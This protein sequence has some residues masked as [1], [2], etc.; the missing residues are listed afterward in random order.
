MQSYDRCRI[1]TNLVKSDLL[2]PNS[3]GGSMRDIFYW[4]VMCLPI[5]FAILLA[6]V[7]MDLVV[8]FFRNLKVLEGVGDEKSTIFW[9]KLG[10]YALLGIPA[11]FFYTSSFWDNFVHTRFYPLE[12]DFGADFDGWTYFAPK[13]AAIFSV[14]HFPMH[15]DEGFS[16]EDLKD[17]W[18]VLANSFYCILMSSD[19]FRFSFAPGDD[20]GDEENFLI[21]ERSS[22]R[23]GSFHVAVSS[24]NQRSNSDFVLSGALNVE[25]ILPKDL[26]Q[27]IIDMHASEFEVDGALTLVGVDHSRSEVSTE[28]I[29]Y[30][31]LLASSIVLTVAETTFEQTELHMFSLNIFSADTVKSVAVISYGNVS[32]DLCGFTENFLRGMAVENLGYL[33]QC[34]ACSEGFLKKTPADIKEG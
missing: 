8:D 11:Y 20:Q 31:R 16:R 30:Q 29:N 32:E 25:G 9:I 15:S 27:R 26:Q 21:S 3:L 10:F 24:S 1:K 5:I 7:G 17:S 34:S 18:C 6:M 19:R 14:K 13:S 28:T 4:V 22:E 12:Q 33:W 2:Q 23:D